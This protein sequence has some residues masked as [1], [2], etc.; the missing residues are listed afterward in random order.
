MHLD[1]LP[2]KARVSRNLTRILLTS[3][4]LRRSLDRAKN[5][6]RLGG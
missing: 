6:K 1:G 2:E 4:F 3:N 5:E